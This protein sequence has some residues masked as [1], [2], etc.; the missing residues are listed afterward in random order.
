MK[1]KV[2]AALL[3]AQMVVTLCHTSSVFATTVDDTAT[4]QE[5]ETVDDS[6]EL[7]GAETP[8]P[9][10]DLHGMEIKSQSIMAREKMLCFLQE[11]QL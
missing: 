2:V 8:T 4:V 11:P 7:Y 9:E 10:S 1:K 6:Q 3:A 5:V